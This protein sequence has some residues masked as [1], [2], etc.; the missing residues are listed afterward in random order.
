MRTS[1]MIHQPAKMDI[2]FAETR[3]IRTQIRTITKDRNKIALFL[4]DHLKVY[5]SH[6]DVS[7]LPKL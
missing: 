1:K 2:L 6:N 3:L 7:Y 5:L 4:V